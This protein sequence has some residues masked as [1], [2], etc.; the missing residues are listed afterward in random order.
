MILIIHK[1]DDIIHENVLQLL[2]FLCHFLGTPSLVIIIIIIIHNSH[3][4]QNS[5]NGEINTFNANKIAIVNWLFTI[6]NK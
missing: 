6:W 4:E 5:L 1:H 2:N 3:I